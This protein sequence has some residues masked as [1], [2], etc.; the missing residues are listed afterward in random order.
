[1]EFP[2]LR[3]DP[4][5]PAMN[6]KSWLTK[7]AEFA[8]VISLF[9]S[10]IGVAI[11]TF[12]A[13]KTYNLSVDVSNNKDQLNR[14]DTLVVKND[15]S[16]KNLITVID[17]LKTQNTRLSGVNDQLI[18]SL[19][20]SKKQSKFLDD[21]LSISS[22]EQKQANANYYTK[23][24]ADSIEFYYSIL[25][26]TSEYN[27]KNYL[28]Y[29][30]IRQVKYVL[31]TKLSIEKEMQ[32]PYLLSKDSLYLKWKNVKDEMNLWQ[33][34]FVNSSYEEFVEVSRDSSG[35]L[36]ELRG[37]EVWRKNRNRY[38]I[39]L[40]NQVYK[41][42]FSSF[43]EVTNVPLKDRNGQNINALDYP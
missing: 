25:N 30:S 5:A 20:E 28:S 16:I 14:L 6:K 19:S 35:H 38:F 11:A 15:S 27:S 43:Y 41:L 10:L 3:I 18:L 24:K 22:A 12:Y 39:H 8:T 7:F 36:K 33:Q 9:I 37:L 21:E 42:F 31:N 13:V 4:N 34:D 2:M 23:H 17:E 32:N 1:M 26:L 29:D 40:I